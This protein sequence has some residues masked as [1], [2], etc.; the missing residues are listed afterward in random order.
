MEDTSKKNG[1]PKAT[2]NKGQDSDEELTNEI[3]IVLKPINIT[4]LHKKEVTMTVPC[5][6][7]VGEFAQ[8]LVNI[9]RLKGVTSSDAN[10]IS[11][12]KTLDHSLSFSD[13]NII[14]GTKI[15]F[16]LKKKA[17]VQAQPLAKP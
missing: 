13:Q 11:G 14:D 17:Q 6:Q 10:F 4:E 3:S 7:K 5:F 12:G 1:Q 16:T 9:M 8:T 2:L 15:I